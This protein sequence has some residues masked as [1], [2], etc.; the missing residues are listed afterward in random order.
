MAKL[1]A[2]GQAISEAD[3]IAKESADISL[4][5]AYGVDNVA[6]NRQFLGSLISNQVSTTELQQRLDLRQRIVNQLPHEVRDYLSS[7][8]GVHTGD[9]IGFWANPDQALPEL[10]QKVQAAE[11]G[12]AAAFSGYG[13]IDAKQAARLAGI[14][15][16]FNGALS[17]FERAGELKG[18]TQNLPGQVASGVSGDD[19]VNALL[20][21]DSDASL[22]VQ[23]EQ[24]RRKAGFS[25]SESVATTSQGAVGLGVANQG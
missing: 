20:A 23:Q 3:Y 4:L 17:G 2:S 11:V 1:I 14:G 22:R 12:G 6:G 9:L 10:Q 24:A 21:G 19:L 13:N 25:D 7:N 5:H 16:D 18:L 8:Y 15:V